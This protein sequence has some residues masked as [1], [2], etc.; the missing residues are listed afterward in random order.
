[1][2][3][4]TEFIPRIKVAPDDHA[5]A[6]ASNR[7]AAGDTVLI[8]SP[9]AAS[10]FESNIPSQ[11][12]VL[13]N[14]GEGGMGVVYLAYEKALDRH[15]AI[16]RLKPALTLSHRE[17]FLKRFFRE[18]QSIAALNHPHIVHIYALGENRDAPYIVMEYVE[19]PHAGNEPTLP[20]PPYTLTDRIGDNGPLPLSD[21]LDLA[22]RLCKAVGYAHSRGV[23]HRDLKPANI[24][25]DKSLQPKIVDFG[26]AR[27]L[28]P[29]AEALTLPGDKMLSM[30]YGAPEQETGASVVD[31]RA[32]IYGLGA[33]LY[34]CLTGENPRYFRPDSVPESLRAVLVKA[35]DPDRDKR[36][37]SIAD[38]EQRLSLVQSPSSIEFPTSRLVWHCKWCQT[39]NPAV[40]RYCEDCGWDGAEYCLECGA[41]TRLGIQYC[42]RCGADARQYEIAV[43]LLER[44][45]RKWEQKDYAFIGGH[46][47]QILGFQPIGA[48]GEKLVAEVRSL[49]RR[50]QA[51]QRRLE[52]IRLCVPAELE[53]KNYSLVRALIAEHNT[54]AAD[55]A[56][57]ETTEKLPAMMLDREI[58]KIGSAL[59]A[60]E[61][62]YAA[63]MARNA[64]SKLDRRNPALRRMLRLA[65]LAPW[66]L[67]FRNT[68]FALAALLA[69][70]LLSAAPVLRSGAAQKSE[71]WTSFYGLAILMHHQTFL[72]RPL[73]RYA[74]WWGA[75]ALAQVRTQPTDP[76]ATAEAEAAPP[77]P[78]P[79]P[80]LSAQYRKDLLKI[81]SERRQQE[82]TLREAYDSA[83]TELLE[84]MQQAGNYEGWWSV[85]H[86]LDRL[87]EENTLPLEI[88]PD[89]PPEQES[90]QRKMIDDAR[91]RAAQHREKMAA[92]VGRHLRELEALRRTLT[93]Q[94]RM[95][96]ASAVNE[97]IKSLQSTPE[98]TSTQ[99]PAPE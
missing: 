32:D 73:S 15:V 93:R 86:E 67:A 22:I 13:N 18:A 91:A 19:G 41:E 69:L 31:E 20:P 17:M 60:R 45:Q 35:L 59:K 23:V 53:K 43:R 61:W 34:F 52:E 33:I 49:Q 89:T 65:R 9:G 26:L 92:T 12:E 58:E 46:A 39:A 51:A 88:L 1:M 71:R 76:I 64:L 24:L 62:Q 29:G 82:R 54:L 38:F 55:R 87:R 48:A 96:K 4:E 14:I 28:S 79:L 30:G 5:F 8:Q 11:Y 63:G 94:G 3:K 98:Y 50:A 90:L 25:F 6:S 42:G 16:K 75:D 83:L 74:A 56:F 84:T 44:L 77:E 99:S 40:V 85:R 21:A 70:Y 66:W 81:E 7:P 72:G 2:E 47:G 95:E 57:A 80:G 10:P 37:L 36:W 78:D 68:T 27:R 97:E